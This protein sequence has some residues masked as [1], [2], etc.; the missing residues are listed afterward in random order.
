M[1]VTSYERLRILHRSLLSKPLSE[2]ALQ[3]LLA[4]LPAYLDNIVSIR[5]ALETEVDSSRQQLQHIQG[6]ITRQWPKLNDKEKVAKGLHEALAPL[7]GR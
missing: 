2:E 1:P 4:N 5:P 6:H 3:E 7:F